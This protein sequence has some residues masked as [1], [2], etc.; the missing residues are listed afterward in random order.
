VEGVMRPRYFEA[1][2]AGNI[3]AQRRIFG[4]WLALTGGGAILLFL[5]F[6]GFSGEIGNWLLGGRFRETAYLMPIVAAGYVPRVLSLMLET[7]CYGH[8]NSRS[9]LS[10]EVSGALMSIVVASIAVT[11]F[12]LI[13]AAAAVPVT[14]A[15]Q[16][17]F[18]ALIVAA[19]RTQSKPIR[20]NGR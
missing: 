19:T 17:M 16:L 3:L 14:F 4:S 11:L 13:G 20:E 18:A 2:A 1:I 5:L 8:G 15:L 9:V 12:G 6:L 10:I 7:R